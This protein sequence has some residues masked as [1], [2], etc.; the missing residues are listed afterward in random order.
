MGSAYGLAPLHGGT[1][2][3]SMTQLYL[4]SIRI[5]DRHTS[6]GEFFL[7]VEDI[8]YLS[9]TLQIFFKDGIKKSI[10]MVTAGYSFKEYLS[11]NILSLFRV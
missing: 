3:W 8:Y 5:Q 10:K 9:T 2:E 6:R 1:T 7:S 4:I 11:F